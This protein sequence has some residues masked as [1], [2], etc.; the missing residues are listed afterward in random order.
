M[1]GTNNG[2][3]GQIL[4]NF[5]T[6]EQQE[7]YL[8]RLASGEWVAAFALTEAEAGSDPAGLR[9]SA[10]RDGDEYVINGAKR[11]ITN[12]PIAD[13]MTLAARTRPDLTMDAVSLFIVDLP[14]D[15]S[16]DVQP[17]TVVARPAAA[18]GSGQRVLYIDDDTAIVFLTARIL[19]RLG[20]KVTGC[21]N[22]LRGV[23]R[24]REA[25]NSFDVVVTDLSMP[26][27]SGFDVARELQAIRP[28][29]PILM[30]SGYVRSE[31]R[32]RA[33]AAGIRD[34]ILKP[35]TVD[36]LGQALAGLFQRMDIGG[37]SDAE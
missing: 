29:V 3:A 16:G 37:G 2:I 9:T 24:F 12:A 28:D 13:F 6:A 23:D 26:Q 14:A 17:K 31:D 5:G 34:V 4:V 21:D 11:F 1:L 22:P 25:P 8:P 33:S 27:M 20:Y 32:E 35:D 15:A 19:E 10:V 7:R 30:T 36:E 18:R